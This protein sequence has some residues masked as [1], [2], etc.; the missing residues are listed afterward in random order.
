MRFGYNTGMDPAIS[1]FAFVV[2]LVAVIN[3]LGIVRLLSSFAEYLRRRRSLQM[4]HFWIYYVQTTFQLLIH[5]LLWWSILGLREAGN[6]NFL[7]YLYLLV[8]PTLLFLSTS[9]LIPD[10]DTEAIDLRSEYLAFRK[11]YYSMIAAFWL[12]VIFIWPVFVGRFAPTVKIFVVYLAISLLQRFSANLKLHG[13]MVVANCI[14]FAVFVGLFAMQL[15]GA[16][17]SM[18]QS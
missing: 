11:D 6:L 7:T 18:M 13:T 12:W 14:L 17:R 10:A 5:V 4:S 1:S 16:A 8:G 3:G 9:L 2:S 15:G